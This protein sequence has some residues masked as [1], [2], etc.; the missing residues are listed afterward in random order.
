MGPFGGT[1]GYLYSGVVYVEGPYEGKVY[2]CVANMYW[3]Q[4]SYCDPKRLLVPLFELIEWFGHSVVGF[5]L[6]VRYLMVIKCILLHAC[7]VTKTSIAQ[8]W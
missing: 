6:E 7:I 5:M 4:F 1:W 8:C 3:V 2:L